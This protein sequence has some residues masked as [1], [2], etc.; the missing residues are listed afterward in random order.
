MFEELKNDGRIENEVMSN[1]NSRESIC[2]LL[3]GHVSVSGD[4][5]GDVT[6]E[7]PNP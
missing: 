6:I 5:N 7:M 2:T 4:A 1:H 3:S